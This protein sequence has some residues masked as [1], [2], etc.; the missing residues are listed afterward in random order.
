MRKVMMGR[1]V[2]KEHKT[3]ATPVL[4]PPD[5]TVLLELIRFQLE[6]PEAI[7]TLTREALLQVISLQNGQNKKFMVV[8]L[9]LLCT[10]SSSHF[11]DKKSYMRWA[12]RQ[13]NLLQE[14]LLFHPHV[15]LDGAT[16]LV[17]D[18]KAL[19][20]QFESS[21]SL[22]HQKDIL[23]GLRDVVTYLASRPSRGE[24]SGESCHW[25]D[26]YHLNV[27]LYKHLLQACLDSNKD[28]ELLEEVDS[29]Q[30]ML[31]STRRS[32]GITQTMHSVVYSGVLFQQFMATGADSPLQEALVQ[33][34]NIPFEGQ[35]SSEE[36]THL[37]SLCTLVQTSEGPRSLSL[38]HTFLTPIKLWIDQQL[39][40]YHRYFPQGGSG[41]MESLLPT[42]MTVW[43]LLLSEDER[44]EQGL[45]SVDEKGPAQICEEYIRSSLSTAFRQLA[46]L[47]E[48]R[49]EANDKHPLALL[50]N[51][52]GS[53]IRKEVDSFSPILKH[54]NR[55]SV[56]IA[57][58]HLHRLFG[59]QLKPFLAEVNVLTDDAR[60]VLPSADRLETYLL[61]LMTDLQDEEGEAVALLRSRIEPYEVTEATGN[62]AMR[63]VNTQVGM[64]QEWTERSITAEKWEPASQTK[65]Y[66]HSVV[67]VFRIIE[68]TLEHFFDL[69]IP[70]RINLLRALTNGIDNCAQ[71]YINRVLTLLGSKDDLMPPLAPL[72]RFK[73]D[74]PQKQATLSSRRTR[75]Q[76][77]L[78]ETR[79]AD[80]NQMT[81]S[82]LCVRLNS[83]HFVLEQLDSVEESVRGHFQGKR[84][85]EE[86]TQ[87][88]RHKGDELAGMFEQSRR[89]AN[90]SIEKICD[91]TGTKVVFWDMRE[92]F[93][94]GLYKASVASARMDEVLSHLDSVL[95]DICDVIA[96][97]LRDKLILSLL[98]SCLD[99]LDRVLLDG[100]PS[101]AFAQSDAEML[102]DD[103]HD[104][105][106]FFI[107]GG[108]GLP[109]GVVES[110]AAPVQQILNLYSLDTPIV[111]DN[112]KR[113][114]DIL[115]SGKTAGTSK[116]RSATDANTLL[117][118]LCH[119]ADRE[120]SKFLKK[121]FKLPKTVT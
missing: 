24:N 52:V 23:K 20:S 36:Q 28:G 79:I 15:R 9:E 93:L 4:G 6:I 95:R 92:V 45:K 54:W 73:K 101:R 62:M 87:R 84:A 83:L 114:S 27:S 68:E 120:A 78:D 8:P 119:R 90:T 74:I 116:V 33:L 63:W 31:K 121:Q 107:A 42:A 21:E 104:L 50:A 17:A 48:R 2:R 39:K 57:A 29:I 34:R 22:N 88:S 66:G 89:V 70:L 19:V 18:M 47:G 117:R 64:I 96:E 106:A 118:V 91:F 100:G 53:L 58:S 72:T 1:F 43:Q 32:L 81:T 105:K 112:F 25:V 77:L 13:L 3:K 59:S 67:D 99:G 115:G 10:V 102:E 69:G 75:D 49:P 30:E 44:N 65:R 109:R 7:D 46:E 98:Q 11:S 37:N 86:K 76:R 12:K 14:G 85:V 94:E 35:R 41:R 60:Q 103:V 97:H 16:R 51:D 56:A 111:V 80:L 82:S 40:D 38:L 108:D 71:L 26:G 61:N 113:S 5:N 55:L 110:A